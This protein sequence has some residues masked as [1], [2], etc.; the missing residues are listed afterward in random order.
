MLR[1]KTVGSYVISEVGPLQSVRMR[2]FTHQANEYAEKHSIEGV[3]EALDEWIS[4]AA[5]CEPKITI[6][7]YLQM[8]AVQIVELVHGLSDVNESDNEIPPKKKRV[9]KRISTTE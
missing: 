7:E 8:P 3:R 4:L 5:C 6:D 9:S 1:T 2:L